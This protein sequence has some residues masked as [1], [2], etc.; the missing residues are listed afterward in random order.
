M[1]PKRQKHEKQKHCFVHNNVFT[2]L[3]EHGWE[4]GTGGVIAPVMSLLGK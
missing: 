3:L 1:R 2:I 4:Q